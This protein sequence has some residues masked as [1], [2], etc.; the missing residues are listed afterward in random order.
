M[1]SKKGLTLIELIV[2][3]AIAGIIAISMLSLF[4]TSIIN[5]IRAGDRTEEV[6]KKKEDIDKTVTFVP[7]DSTT[8]V[9][10]ESL[11]ISVKLPGVVTHETVKG[12]LLTNSDENLDEDF[13]NR[14]NI[15]IK[16]FIPDKIENTP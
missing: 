11:E 10:V 4:N 15:K 6:Y 9:D 8:E 1:K 7:S 5:I 12:T 2:S 3:L 14:F 13:T 16:T